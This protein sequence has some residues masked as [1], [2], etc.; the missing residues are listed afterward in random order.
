MLRRTSIV[1]IGTL[2][3]FTAHSARAQAGVSPRELTLAVGMAQSQRV[4][5]VISPSI[6][7]GSGVDALVRYRRPLFGAD[8]VSSFRGGWRHLSTD[9]TTKTHELAM[10]GELR[11][12]VMQ[13]ERAEHSVFRPV[14][15]LGTQLTST[16]T[17]HHYSNSI[18]GEKAFVFGVAAIGPIARWDAALRGGRVGFQLGAPLTGIVVHPYSAI[19]A[20]RS[21]FEPHAFTP[22]TL[23]S[24]DV[25]LS[26]ATAPRDG[27]AWFG[28][29]RA[30]ATR[31][32]SVL[33]VRGFSQMLY[34]GFVRRA[35]TP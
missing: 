14:F 4:D 21:M 10:D 11:F 30:N 35:T 29:Y 15:G 34:V 8:I 27:L 1:M 9:A 6:Y 18:G 16:V 33:G 20:G 7:D 31:Y 3:V 23:R 5:E 13:T 22:A 25:S 32:D 24:P 26:Y 17:D 19:R 2:A 28:E 12:D